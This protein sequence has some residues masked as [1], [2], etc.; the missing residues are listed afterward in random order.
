LVPRWFGLD[1][2]TEYIDKIHLEHSQK[3]KLMTIFF[4]DPDICSLK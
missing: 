4:S 3:F 2:F 1:G